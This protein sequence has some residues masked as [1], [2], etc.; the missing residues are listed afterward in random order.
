MHIS[1]GLAAPVGSVLLGD[2]EFIRM[3]RRT[4][5]VLGGG[6]RQAGVLAA[7]GI[8][9][10]KTMTGRLLEDHKR[11]FTFAS[12]LS[13]ISGVYV[14]LKVDLPPFPLRSLRFPSPPAPPP[15]H[16]DTAGAWDWMRHRGGGE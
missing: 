4:R 7:C 8:E 1:K 6:M 9:A 2:V 15:R 3:A 5:K 11:A 13:T 16:L 10:L 12:E 14:D